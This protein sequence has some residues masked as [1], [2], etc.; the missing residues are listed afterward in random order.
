MTKGVSL[1]TELPAHPT[2]ILVFPLLDRLDL[3]AT[4]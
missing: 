2:F 4:Q 1:E 3:K